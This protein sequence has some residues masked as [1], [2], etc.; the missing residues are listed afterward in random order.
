MRALW[1][2]FDE[3]SPIR[4]LSGASGVQLYEA[5][6]PGRTRYIL[7]SIPWR[8]GEQVLSATESQRLEIALAMRH[9]RLHAVE[10]FA[11]VQNTL[12]LVWPFAERSAWELFREL[13]QGKVAG[14]SR[15]R[16]VSV[17]SAAAEALDYLH[18]RYRAV[19]RSVKPENL[20]EVDGVWKLADL[21]IADDAHRLPWCT[22]PE[23]YRGRECFA[24]DQYSL[25][26]MY[27]EVRTGRL[28]FLATSPEDL[29]EQVSFR[30]PK[31]SGLHESE[32]EV[33]KRALAVD[34]ADRFASCDAFLQALADTRLASPT[35]PLFPAELK[36]P[37]APTGKSDVPAAPVK[38]SSMVSESADVEARMVVDASAVRR[39]GPIHWF[40]DAERRVILSRVEDFASER[41][42]L[43]APLGDG[44]LTVEIP[45][46]TGAGDAVEPN[47]LL[48]HFHLL[49]R[50]EPS[51]GWMAATTLEH[52][53]SPLTAAEFEEAACVL[54]DEFATAVG[55]R[56]AT[57]VRM[58]DGDR[59][60]FKAAVQLVPRSGAYRQVRIDGEIQDV[61]P[62]GMAVVV[63]FPMSEAAA[64]LWLSPE[65]E[66]IPVR[67][68]Y[69]RPRVESGDY[70]VG[71]KTLDGQ[72]LPDDLL[73]RALT[74]G[75]EA[76]RSDA[77]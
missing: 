30:A 46:P 45:V 10:R 4:L 58:R 74:E 42:F 6:G 43:V 50:H 76:N 14:L 72:P 9:D 16:A 77:E 49:A 12:C 34:P 75:T 65:Q 56:H 73:N 25:A 60:P 27:V 62:R 63:K 18:Q 7:K 26:V 19:H 35:A 1:P 20:L 13:R 44:K 61:S 33:L 55:L 21:S 59:R 29:A 40:A 37:T 52:Y 32:Q 3:F 41:G 68:L 11:W 23:V 5:R 17:L 69:H 2:T 67:L 47:S 38:P 8:R 57:N 48:L 22:A 36:K 53:D 51:I 39:L 70:T 15:E 31:L 66:P 64:D 24:S 54:L 28:P 71:L